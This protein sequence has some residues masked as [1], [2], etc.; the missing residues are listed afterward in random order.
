MMLIN[1]FLLS[2]VGFRRLGAQQLS[3]T[4]DAQQAFF[5]S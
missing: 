2:E 4:S 5:W 1:H 3:V